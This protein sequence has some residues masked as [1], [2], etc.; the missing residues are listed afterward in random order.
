MTIKNRQKKFIITLLLIVLGYLGIAASIFFCALRVNTA[1]ADTVSTSP[2]CLTNGITTSDGKSSTGSPSN[3]DVYMKSSRSSGSQTINNG[4]LSNWSQYYVMVDAID[5]TEHLRLDLYKSGSLYK[6]IDV[7]GDADITTNFGSLPSGKYTLRYECRYKKN[8]FTSNVYYI[9]EYVFEVDVTDPTY[10]ISAGTDGSYYTN[11]NIYYSA[12]DLHFSHIRYRRGTET[13]FSY[14]YGNSYSIAATEANNGYWYFYA[15]DTLG[16]SSPIISRYLDTIAPV[17]TVTNQDEVVIANGSATNT[18]FIYSASDARTVSSIEY[19][20][21]TVTTWSAYPSNVSILNS[22]GWYY[23]RA[24]DGAGNVSDEYRVYYDTTKPLGAVFDSVSAKGSGSVTNKDYVKYTASDSGSGVESVYVK[25]PGSSAFV[26]YTNGSQLTTEGTYYFKAYD[27]AG[28]IT[29]TTH[30][31]TLDK[32]A[33]VGQ[34]KIT[35]INVS[36]NSYTNQSF[37]YTAT[38]AVGVAILQMKRPNSSSWITYTAG[39]AITG[40]EGWYSFRATDLAG[41][42]SG[43]SNIFYDTSKPTVSLIKASSGASGQVVESG[44]R[45]NTEC[46]RATAVDMGSGIAY[47]RVWGDNYSSYASYVAGTELTKE[48][49]Y[50]FA[51]MNKAGIVSDIYEIL[52]DK[53]PAAGYIYAGES[54]PTSDSLTNAAYICYEAL[55]SYSDAVIC[56]VKKPG[57]TSFEEYTALTKLTEEGEY[58]FYSVDEAG[59]RSATMKI[60]VNRS[61]PTAQ[62]YADGVTIAN[63]S[64]TNKQYIKF[65]SNGTCYVKKPGATSFISYISGTEFYEE[66]RYE[67]YAENAAGTQTARNVIIIDREPTVGMLSRVN[68]G[69]SWYNYQLSWLKWNPDE[70]APVT[71]I[72][73]NGYN[74]EFDSVIYTLEGKEYKVVVYDAAGNEWTTSFKGGRI[75]VPTITLQKVYWEYTNI[76]TNETYS[77]NQYETALNNA[78]SNQRALCEFKSWNTETW[79]Q[80]IPM[81]TKDSVNAKNGTYYLYKSEENPNIKVAYFTEERLNEVCRKYANENVKS[82]Y[83]WEKEP[84]ECMGTN[85]D[86]YI[87]QNKIVSTAVEL[88]EGLI[89]T[90]DGVRYTELTITKPGAHTLLIEDGYGGSVEYEIYIL[91]S[92]PTLQYALGDNS[93]TKAEYD[94]TYYFRDRVTIS[95]PF[96][97]DELAMFVVYYENGDEVGYFDMGDTCTI[98]ESGIYSAMAVN[99][100]GETKEFK[101]VVSMNAPT[102]TMTENTE[103]KTL[104]I[105]LGESTDKVSHI[106]FLEISK[107]DDGGETWIAL[108]KDDYGKVITVDTLNYN[109]RTSAM[110]RVTIMDEFRTGIDAIVQTIEY[111]QPIPVG[112]LAGVEDKGYTNKTVTFTWKDEAVVNLTKDGVAVEY[113]SGQKLTANGSYVLTFSNYD[114]YSKTYTFVIDTVAPMVTLEGAKSGEFV[115]AGVKAHFAKDETAQIFKDGKLLGLYLGGSNIQEDGVYRI[116]VK[117][118]ALNETA[119]TFTIDTTVDWSININEKGLSNSVVVTADEDVEVILTKDGAVVEY[120]LGEAITEIGEYSLEIIDSLG[121]T[122]SRNFSIV[123]PIVRE[124]THNFDDVPGFEKV[125]VNGE[126]KRLNYGTLELFVDGVYEVGVV[127]NGET[128]T[129]TVTVDSTLPE[130]TLDG[131][132]NGGA[133]NGNVTL[134]TTEETAT[135]TVYLNG[136]EIAYTAGDELTAEGEYRVVATDLANNSVEVTF[137]IDKTAPVLTLTGVENVGVTNG[138]V[139]ISAVDY[140]TVVVYLNDAEIEYTLGD[141]LAEEGAYFVQAWDAVGNVLD[142]MFVIDKTGPVLTLNGVEKDGKTNCNVLVDVTD[143]T[144]TL[145]VYLN[146]EEINYE[147]GNELKS[148]GVHLITAIDALGNITE[149]SFTIDKTAPTIILNGVENK[150]ATRKTVSLG[151]SSEEAMVTVYFNDEE[152]AYKQGDSLTKVGKYR[153][154]VTD[155]SNNASEYTFTIE[156]KVSNGEIALIVIGC[157]GVV[158]GIVFFILKKRKII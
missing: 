93:P 70:N 116:V 12:D 18:Q 115:N 76:F 92:A 21:P 148:E 75:D 132:E 139:A 52:L 35:N 60:T 2:Y 87:G 74:Y 140:A 31:I 124:F 24:I 23:F 27:K 125:L 69:E 81:D 38:D 86:A 88:R 107:S 128:Y 13:T 94:R 68:G 146:G 142:M 153:V 9:Y 19:K 77:C 41:N 72:T 112:T 82:Y 6:S 36:N 45:V 47:M 20:S 78:M 4:Y 73:I 100:F 58:Q 25:K 97:G 96:E 137:S 95:V 33:P 71:R 34:L 46:I 51:A 134:A 99:H 1:S 49:R 32:T 53:T 118:K 22:N 59:N 103:K 17:G 80:G 152:I 131:V 155:S 108:T 15:V 141:E 89:Y 157:L 8:I 7:S 104:N 122:E 63:G 57:S 37:T 48:G 79:D 101:F 65:V 127:V 84:A 14:Y 110:Y 113:K 105:A 130:I 91:N 29:S 136:E 98:E 11:K 44:S 149:I 42:V 143:D 138:N 102:I 129:F 56:Y 83:Y 61:I 16:N 106:S 119:V 90:L 111:K 54:Y 64:Y 144:S 66:G 5:V 147:H 117:D 10:S 40:A 109:F 55:D 30:E 154:V 156:K 114:G 126:D 145:K 123:T 120:T 151:E 26:S 50:Y 67:F 62:L 121:N 133:T 135:L 39:T 3:F 85:L 158:G 43:E 28:N 150:G